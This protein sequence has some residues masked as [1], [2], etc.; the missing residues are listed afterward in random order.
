M[1]K[2]QKVEICHGFKEFSDFI[3]R[4]NIIVTDRNLLMARKCVNPFYMGRFVR[5]KYKFYSY[6]KEFSPYA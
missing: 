4:K 2:L 6:V 5:H 1:L 3:Q